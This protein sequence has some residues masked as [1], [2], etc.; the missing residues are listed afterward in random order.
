[1]LLLENIYL[2]VLFAHSVHL[3]SQIE[4]KTLKN[5][6]IYWNEIG[7]MNIFEYRS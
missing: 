7:A 2:F 3:L 5:E 4:I 6:H 1:M